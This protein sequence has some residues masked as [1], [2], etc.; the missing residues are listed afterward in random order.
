MRQQ[1][2]LF[3]AYK[4]FNKYEETVSNNKVNRASLQQKAAPNF[5]HAVTH[6]VNRFSVNEINHDCPI[7][8]DLR[9]LPWV[10]QQN[11]WFLPFF[12]TN[13]DEKVILTF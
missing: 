3:I 8:V 11:K 12:V 9:L 7:N 6:H 1:E 10:L 2:T 13:T 4:L 5:F